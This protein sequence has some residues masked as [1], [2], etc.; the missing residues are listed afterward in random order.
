MGDEEKIYSVDEAVGALRA[1]HGKTVRIACV[2][3]LEFEGTAVVHFPKA[4]CSEY[5]SELWLRL[6]LGGLDLEYEGLKS[7]D[8]R[9]VV[10][11]GTLDE[12]DHGHM[13]LWPGAV[14]ATGIQKLACSD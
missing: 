8:G 12:T 5:Q 4:E 14:L 9:R 1:L 6:D 7:F 10:V 2:L 11:T 3:R 13:S